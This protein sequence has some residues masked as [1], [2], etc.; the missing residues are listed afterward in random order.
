V[1]KKKKTASDTPGLSK[2]KIMKKTER[3]RERKKTDI[4]DRSREREREKKKS[5][6]SS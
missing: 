3:E 5:I 1:Y 2:K 6:A 4:S